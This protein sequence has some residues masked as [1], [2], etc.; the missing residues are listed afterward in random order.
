VACK[1]CI[2]SAQVREGTLA[3]LSQIYSTQYMFIDREYL[4]KVIPKRAWRTRQR[5]SIR[6]EKRAE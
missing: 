2:R 6:E 5:G 1:R 3:L 4:R